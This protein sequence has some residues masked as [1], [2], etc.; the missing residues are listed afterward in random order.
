MWSNRAQPFQISVIGFYNEFS[1][2]K[3]GA[4]LFNCP[5]DGIE[6]LFALVPYF[7]GA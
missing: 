5:F 3:I 1:T 6:F 7:L 2:Q 4:P